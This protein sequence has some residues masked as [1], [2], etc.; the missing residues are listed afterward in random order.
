MSEAFP[1]ISKEV[2]VKQCH[3]TDVLSRSPTSF[4]NFRRAWQY[5]C[6][7]VRMDIRLFISIDY[8]ES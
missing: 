7:S 6:L 3:N 5:V 4:L 1:A 8:Y 2:A